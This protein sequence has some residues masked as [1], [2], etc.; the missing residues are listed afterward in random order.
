MALS[1]SLLLKVVGGLYRQCKVVDVY[2][3]LP[4][5]LTITPPPSPPPPSPPSPPPPPPLQVTVATVDTDEGI[6]VR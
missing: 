4:P 2:N 1:L 6:V 3:L 5:T